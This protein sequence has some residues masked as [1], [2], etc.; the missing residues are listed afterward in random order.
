MRFPPLDN[1]FD[2]LCQKNRFSPLTRPFIGMNPEIKS[3]P[4]LKQL[5]L[6]NQPFLFDSD[7]ESGNLDMA[8]QTNYRDF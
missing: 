3:E 5:N 2:A 8:V 1:V 4:F 6:G 7:F